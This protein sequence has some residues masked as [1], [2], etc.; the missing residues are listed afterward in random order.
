[1][2]GNDLCHIRCHTSHASAATHPTILLEM[3]TE[4]VYGPPMDSSVCGITWKTCTT[5]R[6]DPDQPYDI[7]AKG[8]HMW[9]VR[10]RVCHV[11]QIYTP[12][13]LVIDLDLCDTFE[14]E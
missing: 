9:P 13:R 10:G 3:F 12:P 6:W 14:Y 8:C 11:G 4:I 1:M 2:H 5:E 7:I